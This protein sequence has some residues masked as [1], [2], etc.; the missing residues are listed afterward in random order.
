MNRIFYAFLIFLSFFC[1]PS[2]RRTG[3]LVSVGEGRHAVSCPVSMYSVSEIKRYITSV[4]RSD[5]VLDDIYGRIESGIFA[6]A[7]KELNL[8]E[9]PVKPMFEWMN[10]CEGLKDVKG[11]TALTHGYRNKDGYHLVLLVDI[12]FMH[13]DESVVAELV[14]HEMIHAY[15][16]HWALPTGDSYHEL[17]FDAIASKIEELSSRVPDLDPFNGALSHIFR[18]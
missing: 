3:G 10:F 17:W 5:P 7:T 4:N 11:A 15:C 6:H 1:L 16:D 18:E 12:G 14:A 9:C 13:S 8:R 2:C